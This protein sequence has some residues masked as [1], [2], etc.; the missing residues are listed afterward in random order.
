MDKKTRKSRKT[1][2]LIESLEKNEKLKS[3]SHKN[4]VILSTLFMQKTHKKSEGIT[5]NGVT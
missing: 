4:T 3:E 1:H 5:K 2:F